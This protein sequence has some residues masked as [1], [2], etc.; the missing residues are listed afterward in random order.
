MKDLIDVHVHIAALTDAST[1]CFLKPAFEKKFIATLIK[2]KL[3][4]KGSSNAERN[5]SYVNRLMKDINESQRV[6]KAVILAFDATYDE[7]GEVDW[8]HTTMII[9]NEHVFSLAKEFPNHFIP[10]AS[11]NPQRKDALEELSRVVEKGAKLIKVLPNSQNFDPGNPR[12][13]PFYRAV[14]D[15]HIPILT[16]MGYEFT[17]PAVRQRYGRLKCWEMALEEGVTLIAAH[18]GSSGLFIPGT[19]FETFLEYMSRY[20]HLFADI[21]GTTLPDRSV[22]LLKLRRRPELYERFLFGTDYPIAAY[23][24]SFIGHFKL[25]TQ[26]RLFRM[27]NI[28]D[29]QAA[30]FDALGLGYNPDA[31]ERLLGEQRGSI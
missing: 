5:R 26:W 3:G 19:W 15:K 25:A 24:S 6:R 16:H 17:I 31:L 13:R 7:Q 8:D 12:Y 9:P 14:R 30:V 11:I 27:K 22:T 1:G 2:W 20:P 18:V 23:A 28:F 21:S 29:K 10:G 4:L